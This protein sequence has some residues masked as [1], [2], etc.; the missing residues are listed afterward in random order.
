MLDRYFLGNRL[1][2][3]KAA[4][5]AY[6]E[7]SPITYAWNISTP[8]LIL[9]SIGD[10]TVPI[11]HSYELFHALRDR[12][13]PVQFIAYNSTEH[14]PSDPISSEDIYRRWVGWFDRYLH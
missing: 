9:G 8:T 1:W 5:H 7:Q 2:A 4:F 11:T 6:V 10:T 3:S 14:F 13:V 12:G